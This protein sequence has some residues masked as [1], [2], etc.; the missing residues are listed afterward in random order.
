MPQAATTTTNSSMLNTC[1][2]VCLAEIFGICQVSTEKKVSVVEV[3]QPLCVEAV[4]ISSSSSY[5]VYNELALADISLL[6]E[7]LLLP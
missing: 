3:E 2:Q 6:R 5:T 1:N 7:Y 4:D